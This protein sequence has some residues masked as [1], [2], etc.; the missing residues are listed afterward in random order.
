MRSPLVPV[1]T[2]AL[3]VVL[4]ATAALV[5]ALFLRT[6]DP[7]PATEVVVG[8]SPEGATAEPTDDD[9]VSPPPPVTEESTE[10]EPE[11]EPAPEPSPTGFPFDCLDGHS[12]QEH[13]DEDTWD[14]WWETCLDAR[15]GDDDH[16]D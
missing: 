10:P 11:P 4:V 16:D 14:D 12:G 2:G 7:A 13:W 9:V 5:W 8:A 15:F 3:T 1:V 6:P